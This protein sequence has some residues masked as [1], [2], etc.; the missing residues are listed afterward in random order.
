VIEKDMALSAALKTIAGSELAKHAVFKG[1]TAI[2]KA[3]FAE[4]RFSE[5]LDFTSMDLDKNG[6]LR[7]LKDALEG[8]TINEAITFKELEEEKTSAGIRAAVKYRGPLEHA[9][10]IKFDFNFREN[11]AEKPLARKMIDP[12]RF[13]DAE[14]QVMG[15]E[16]IFAEKLHAL[17]SRSAPRDLY[18]AWFLFGKGIRI[19]RRVLDRK[20][21]YYDE[22]FDAKKAV[23][24][25]RKSRDNWNKALRHLLKKLPEVSQIELEVEKKLQEIS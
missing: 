17:C 8:R 9:Q 4:A 24:N 3:Y 25:A 5:D 23:E 7:L 6:C 18:D 10:R 13:G 1:G 15:I 16:E 2:K 21:A 19:D 11:L 14:L 20:F 22:T 12:Y